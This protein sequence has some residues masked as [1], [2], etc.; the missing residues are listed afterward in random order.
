MQDTSV[1][2]QQLTL[3]FHLDGVITLDPDRL[4]DDPVWGIVSAQWDLSAGEGRRR[5]LSEY[6]SRYLERERLLAQNPCT[7]GPATPTNIEIEFP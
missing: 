5:A 7:N 3:R 4:E 1:N 6:L 2:P